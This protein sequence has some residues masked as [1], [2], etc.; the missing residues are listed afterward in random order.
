MTD[1]AL[2]VLGPAIVGVLFLAGWEAVVHYFEIP[3]YVLPGPA[4]V[5]ET[6]WRDG[7]SLRFPCPSLQKRSNCS[8]RRCAARR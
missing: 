3:W 2:R 8:R 1:R 6:L 4:V 7:P 5:A